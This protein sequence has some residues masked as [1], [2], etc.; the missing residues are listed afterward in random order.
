LVSSNAATKSFTHHLS[1]N[2]ELTCVRTFMFCFSLFLV[3]LLSVCFSD[4]FIKLHLSTSVSHYSVLLKYLPTLST[5]KARFT[6]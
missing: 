4:I 5:K 1:I 3:F 2:A 6:F